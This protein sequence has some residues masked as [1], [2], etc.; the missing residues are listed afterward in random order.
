MAAYQQF[1][2]PTK[3]VDQIVGARTFAAFHAIIHAN[4]TIIQ[5]GSFPLRGPATGIPLT[6]A[7]PLSIGQVSTL[8][9]TLTSPSS[10]WIGHPKYRRLPPRPNFLIKCDTSNVTVTVA[11][12]LNN[13]GWRIDCEGKSYWAFSFAGHV[14]RAMAKELFAEFASPHKSSMWSKD[15]F[16]NKAMDRSRRSREF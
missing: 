12:D 1:E 3:P 14:F 15:A 9:E 11:V 8:R 5:R 10:Y 2:W 7:R 6:E 13:S 4:A 16:P